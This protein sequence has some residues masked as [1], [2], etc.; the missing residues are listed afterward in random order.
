MNEKKIA[1]IIYIILILLFISKSFYAE[2][3]IDKYIEKY[4]PTI[5]GE[6]AKTTTTLFSIPQK[7]PT[8][9]KKY[10]ISLFTD[11]KIYT[12]PT[13]DTV[14]LTINSSKTNLTIQN[15]SIIFPHDKGEVVSIEKEVELPYVLKKR[16][17]INKT[18]TCL[19]G[20][21]TNFTLSCSNSTNCTTI[22][23]PYYY[24]KESKEKRVCSEGL[25][26]F[27]KVCVNEEFWRTIPINISYK[28]QFVPLN[29]SFKDYLEK[30]WLDSWSD[31]PLLKKIVERKLNSS[32]KIFERIREKKNLKEIPKIKNFNF[33]H[34]NYSNFQNN[35]RIKRRIELD[36]ITN[37]TQRYRIKISYPV[38][39][40]GEFWFVATLEDGREVVLDPW[41]D[42]TYKVKYN[43]TLNETYDR[44]FLRLNLTDKPECYEN[45]E[46]IRILQN[47]SLLTYDFYNYSNDYKYVFTYLNDLN[48][49][50]EI[51][52]N[53]TSNTEWG[54]SSFVI[55]FEDGRGCDRATYG[56]LNYYK[57][58][59]DKRFG[60]RCELYNPSNSGDAYS[61]YSFENQYGEVYAVFYHMSGTSLAGAQ[62]VS[63]T[64][65]SDRFY[66]SGTQSGLY[67]IY[68]GS[69]HYLHSQV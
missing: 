25:K 32:H 12:G 15:L 36:R 46:D 34:I 57:S 43:V 13:G 10:S 4:S 52:C 9:S 31:F 49:T 21:K 33:T 48:K 17:Y 2:S 19:S 5:I 68:D 63:L 45:P 53:S 54:N 6:I 41:W 56:S 69:T 29:F 40:Q 3:D 35:F 23:P 7:N 22:N 24:C 1:W 30:I 59:P 27:K 50:L 60:W 62:E 16:I 61:E 44:L 18:Y 66:M 26:L 11:K 58:V 38:N 67:R 14:I 47:G 42:D 39:S 65:G 37:K 55:F 20:W 64:D 8:P 28:K 51:Y